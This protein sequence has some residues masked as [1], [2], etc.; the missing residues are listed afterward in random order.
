MNRHVH[1][2]LLL[3]QLSN[4]MEDVDVCVRSGERQREWTFEVQLVQQQLAEFIDTVKTREVSKSIFF[5]SPQTS[6]FPPPHSQSYFFFFFFPPANKSVRLN[7]YIFWVPKGKLQNIKI[8]NYKED[9]YMET[10]N[11]PTTA[12]LLTVALVTWSTQRNP[13]FKKY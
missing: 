5:L 4:L 10:Q 13:L 1:F 6:D 12:L 3:Y 8:T 11:L 7:I 2:R 9:L